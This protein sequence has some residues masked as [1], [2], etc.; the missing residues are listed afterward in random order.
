MLVP[1]V[2]SCMTR[3]I[4]SLGCFQSL[5]KVFEPIP[6]KNKTKTKH[7]KTS[8]FQPTGQMGQDEGLL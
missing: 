7:K 8:I 5:S 1:S 4:I 2:T 6:Q 3:V